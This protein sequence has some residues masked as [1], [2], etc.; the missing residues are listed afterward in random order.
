MSTEYERKLS[1]ISADKLAGEAIAAG[2]RYRRPNHLLGEP[3][4]DDGRAGSEHLVL[5]LLEQLGEFRRKLRP[6]APENDLLASLEELTE[7]VNVVVVRAR[8]MLQ[9]NEASTQ[10]L[11][12]DTIT[13]VRP[14]TE[15]LLESARELAS[16]LGDVAVD[17]V[18]AEDEL[19]GLRVE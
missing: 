16:L 12:C 9:V 7:T 13:E 14:R 8:L 3:V 4:R 1:R 17:V 11:F 2:N 10:E 18:A 5:G 6:S 15:K 19:L